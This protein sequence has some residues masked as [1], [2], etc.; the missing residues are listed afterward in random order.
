MVE[1]PVQVGNVAT[2]SNETDRL[3]YLHRRASINSHAR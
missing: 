3:S 1:G 2:P